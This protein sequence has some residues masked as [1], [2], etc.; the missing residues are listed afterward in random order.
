MPPG[1]DPT[2]GSGPDPVP[3]PDPVP[4]P[5]AAPRP[6]VGGLVRR[7]RRLA[8]LSQRGLGLAS[9]VPASVLSH[10]E[11]GARDLSV[12]QLADVAAVVGFRIA[13]LDEVGAEMVPMRAAAVRDL[14]GRRFPAHVD[15]DLQPSEAGWDAQPPAG[16]ERWYTH[17]RGQPLRADDHRAP[18]PA[19]DPARRRAARRQTALRAAH[20]ERQR[21]SAVRRLAPQPDPVP[22]CACPSACDDLLL[23]EHPLPHALQRVPHVQECRCRC[24][25][26]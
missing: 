25:V 20:V 18:D 9:D 15:V 1:P 11:R 14:G 16:T 6:D 13:L 3:D 5:G 26:A 23:A 10:V 19:D 22:A 8:G 24:D 4:R 2:A 21:W 12:E 17:R 7:A